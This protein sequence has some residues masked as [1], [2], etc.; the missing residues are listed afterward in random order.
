MY[1]DIEVQKFV[2]KEVEKQEY[3]HVHIMP[4]YITTKE[5]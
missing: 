4:G 3:F 5:S 2:K 1:V